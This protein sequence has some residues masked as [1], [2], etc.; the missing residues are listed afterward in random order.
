MTNI[1]CT[2]QSSMMW[3]RAL[4]FILISLLGL[5]S[6]KAAEDVANLRG[7]DEALA[8]HEPVD[9]TIWWEQ[10]RMLRPD[11][12]CPY[13]DSTNLSPVR[14]GQYGSSTG[15]CFYMYWDPTKCN[16][17]SKCPLYV[18]VDGTIS[19]DF[20]DRDTVFMKEMAARGYVAVTADYDDASMGYID[21]CQGFERKSQ[22]IFDD[23][24]V[25]SVLHQL[26][27]DDNNAFGHRND[28]PVDCNKGVA[29]NG[30][31]Q[32]SHVTALAGNF[33]P[34]VTAGL[35]WGNGNR[36]K[37]CAMKYPAC[38]M[39]GSMDVPCMNSNQIELPKEKRRYINGDK[40]SY[41][42]ACE[43]WFGRNNRNNVIDQLQA[44]SGMTCPYSQNNCFSPNPNQAG[45][46]VAIG[47]THDFM[48][49]TPGS[50]FMNIYNP[51]GLPQTFD[52]LAE[53][54]YIRQSE[55]KMRSYDASSTGMSFPTSAVTQPP[56][57]APTVKQ[58]IWQRLKWW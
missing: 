24:T 57:S 54:A 1:I 7:S 8:R 56:T 5:A 48:D 46:Y 31:S 33:S 43:N 35:Y 50:F 22:K 11:T 42:G 15:D 19:G 4:V 40:D 53:E 23:S 14:S 3:S 32:G 37:L 34:L 6:S 44:I 30:Y 52:W 12:V 21:G 38:S 58:S 26:C 27:Q 20:D 28:V 47:E 13:P 36:G 10:G 45:Y 25:G 39:C 49:V 51:W 16:M 18:Y 2:I 29:V 17:K 9:D 55:E 41:F